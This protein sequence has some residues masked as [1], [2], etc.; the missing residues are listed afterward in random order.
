MAGDSIFSHEQENG[1]DSILG[2][3]YQELL[4]KQDKSFSIKY[5]SSSSDDKNIYLTFEITQSNLKKFDAIIFVQEMNATNEV[6]I[7]KKIK[8]QNS[9]TQKITVSFLRQKEFDKFPWQDGFVYQATITCDSFSAQTLEFKLKFEKEKDV[10]KNN[11]SKQNNVLRE[12]WYKDDNGKYNYFNGKTNSDKFANQAYLGDYLV[13]A[14]EKTNTVYFKFKKN[15]EDSVD[16]NSDIGYKFRM[17]IAESNF[18]TENGNIKKDKEGKVLKDKNGKE[19]KEADKKIAAS[20]Y[21]LYIISASID[22]R[23]KIGAKYFGDTYQ[24]VV[25]QSG[26]Y[27]G[28]SSS[29]YKN[30]IET[31]NEKWWA[32]K[33]WYGEQMVMEYL[34]RVHQAVVHQPESERCAVS[35]L[36]SNF[37]L[38]DAEFILAYTHNGKYIFIP[39]SYPIEFDKTKCWI[40]TVESSTNAFPE[41]K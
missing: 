12:G 37:E 35:V 26:Q 14:D 32:G 16:L 20:T 38:K 39:Y 3:W 15:W 9:K 22:N 1:T 34:G 23:K 17:V 4:D 7:N 6:A 27:D 5:V 40:K 25:E 13:T 10:N 28:T 24:E 31:L 30:L 21:E 18:K 19:L 41:L 11:N 29:V 36:K 8:L 33:N 2:N